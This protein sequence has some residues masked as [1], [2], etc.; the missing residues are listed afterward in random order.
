MAGCAWIV[1]RYPEYFD[2]PLPRADRMAGCAAYSAEQATF[3]H[4]EPASHGLSLELEVQRRLSLP[5]H[6]SAANARKESGTKQWHRCLCEPPLAGKSPMN[7]F[8]SLNAYGKWLHTQGFFLFN[9]F[10]VSE[11]G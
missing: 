3:R 6:V 10:N 2:P 11:F 1:N 4:R 7:S 8:A 5:G 9:Y